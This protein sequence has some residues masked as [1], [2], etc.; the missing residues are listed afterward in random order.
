MKLIDKVRREIRR[1]NYSYS[2]EKHYCRWIIRFIR[3]YQ[4][5]HPQNLKEKDIVEFLNHLALSGNVAAST[6]NQALCAIVFLYKEVRKC[7][8]GGLDRL[9]NPLDE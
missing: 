2:T 9:K 7:P 6:Q 8:V 4:L 1:R 5:N 3:F